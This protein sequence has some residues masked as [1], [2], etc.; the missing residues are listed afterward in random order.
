MKSFYERGR[1]VGLYIAKSFNSGRP[2][3]WNS[4]V[5][6]VYYEMWLIARKQAGGGAHHLR[7]STP[8]TKLMLDKH[9]QLVVTLTELSNLREKHI[10]MSKELSALKRKK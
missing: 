5:S 8:T 6:G 2:T 10:A 7:P 1:E 3:K 9:R 4:F